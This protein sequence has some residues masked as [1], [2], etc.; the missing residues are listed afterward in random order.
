MSQAQ[1]AQLTQVE[2]LFNGNKIEQIQRPKLTQPWKVLKEL[3]HASKTWEQMD[4]KMIDEKEIRLVD[5]Y[6]TRT[7]KEVRFKCSCITSTNL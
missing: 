5:V 6:K 2:E 7:S 3:S 1:P 4:F